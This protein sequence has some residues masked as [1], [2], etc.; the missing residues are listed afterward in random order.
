M[1]T[2]SPLS[3]TLL[4]PPP[5]RAGAAGIMRPPNTGRCRGHAPR[6]RSPGT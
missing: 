2:N 5:I 3:W 4:L 6:G 1:T